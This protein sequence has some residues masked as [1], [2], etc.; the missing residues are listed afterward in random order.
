MQEALERE[1][2]DAKAIED[3]AR[4]ADAMQTVQSHMLASLIDCQRKTADRV[5][6]LVANATAVKHKVE[7]AQMLW[8]LLRYIVAIGG[9]AGLMKLLGTP[10]AN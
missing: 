3:P 2:N 1:L 5:K 8:T 10:I 9:G 4:R 6:E 7:G